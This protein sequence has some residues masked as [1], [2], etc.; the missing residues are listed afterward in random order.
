MLVIGRFGTD[1]DALDR[2]CH[3]PGEYSQYGRGA[4]L[5]RGCYFFSVFIS[6]KIVFLYSQVEGI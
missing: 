3:D 6:M 4:R 2:Y 5:V 1:L